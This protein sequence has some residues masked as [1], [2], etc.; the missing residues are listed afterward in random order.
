MIWRE[1]MRFKGALAAVLSGGLLVAVAVSAT[2]QQAATPQPAIMRFPLGLQF[3]VPPGWS[4]AQLEFN[5]AANSVVI[6]YDAKR[7]QDASKLNPNQ[8]QVVF[9]PKVAA[10]ETAQAARDW[11]RVDTD[12]SQALPNGA[13]VWWKVGRKWNA[14]EALSGRATIASTT[15]AFNHTDGSA[16]TFNPAV[17]EDVLL[18]IAGSMRVVA[19]SSSHFHPNLR[20]AIDPP[21]AKRWSL[22]MDKFAFRLHCLG[23]GDASK[24]IAVLPPKTAFTDLNAALAFLTNEAGKQQNLN[25]GEVRREGTGDGEIAWTE[26]LGS[27]WPYFGAFRRGDRYFFISL[28]GKKTTAAM[29][30]DLRNDFLATARGVR[31]GNGE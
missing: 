28:R 9:N 3:E 14:H 22:D 2:A 5:S 8:L 19:P 21:D 7:P 20:M 17:L 13:R 23:C 31:V 10:T 15:L 30:G 11:T 12:R 6:S 26:Q 27:E 25:I 24:I 16:R 4:W 29:D 18:K 1:A